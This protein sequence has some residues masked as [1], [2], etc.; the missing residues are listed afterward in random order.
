MKTKTKFV[1]YRVDGSMKV[2]FGGETMKTP[3]AVSGLV[4]NGSP[5]PRSPK[6]NR[7]FCFDCGHSIKHHKEEGK[8][9]FGQY[10]VVEMRKG[11]AVFGCLCCA[12]KKEV[13]NGKYD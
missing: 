11:K 9:V 1:D 6:S 7:I 10:C 3:E 2:Y 12:S 13:E 4:L 8:T 5:R